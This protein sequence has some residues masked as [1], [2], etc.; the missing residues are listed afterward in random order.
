MTVKEL[1]EILSQADES[2]EGKKVKIEISRK[3][4][5]ATCAEYYIDC[6]LIHV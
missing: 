4:H 1:K 6:F 3:E 2:D 5:L